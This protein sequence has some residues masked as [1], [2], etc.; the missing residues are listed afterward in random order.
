MISGEDL[1][2]FRAQLEDLIQ[3]D[4]EELRRDTEEVKLD[5][6]KLEAAA[7]GGVG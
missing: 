4:Y 7:Y 1:I 3:R 6:Q 5:Q 2:R